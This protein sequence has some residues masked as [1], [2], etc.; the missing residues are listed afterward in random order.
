MLRQKVRPYAFIPALLLLLAGGALL[1]RS[2]LFDDWNRNY[3]GLGL[4]SFAPVL[5]RV[6]PAVVSIRV[7]TTKKKPVPLAQLA[8]DGKPHPN[9]PDALTEE[10]TTAG[11]SG[12]IIDAKKGLIYTNQHVITNAS[13]VVVKLADGNE[14][15]GKVLGSD[16]GTDVA[17]VQVDVQKVGKQLVSVPFANSDKLRVGDIV[18]T[19]GTP[20]GLAGTAKLG[21]VSALM[22]SD[23]APEIFEDFIQIDTVINPGNS[24][25][26]MVDTRGRLAGVIAASIGNAGETA[27]GFVIPVNMARSIADQIVAGGTVHRGGIGFATDSLT[28]AL[29]EKHKLPFARGA[30]IMAV[31]PNSPASR[32]GFRED[33]VIVGINRRPIAGSSDYTARI[34]SIPIGKPVEL[35]IYSKGRVRRAKLSVTDLDI[36]PLPMRAPAEATALAGLTLGRLVPG[37]PEYGKIRGARVLGIADGSAVAQVGL[38]PND[39]IT[40]VNDNVVGTPEDVFAKAMGKSGTVRIDLTRNGQPAYVDITR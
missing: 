13:E 3:S 22:R 28:P 29:V 10:M 34:A 7:S 1:L 18:L 27:I 6:M 14:I 30:M 33:D 40:K 20:Y 15:P 32:S 37:A 11:G 9:N 21:I 38:L 35:D 16:I 31:V 2:P 39:I 4:Y 12:S 19:V 36:E 25:G 17:V 26:A 24:G 23:V 8:E 5:D